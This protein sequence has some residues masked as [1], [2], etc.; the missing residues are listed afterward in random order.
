MEGGPILNQHSEE[1]TAGSNI[2]PLEGAGENSANHEGENTEEKQGREMEAGGKTDYVMDDQHVNPAKVFV[3]GLGQ[4]T[5]T[6]SLRNYFGQYGS[7]V[8]AAVVTDKVSGRSRGFGFC[9]FVHS[10]SADACLNARHKID[11]VSC[12]V[13]RAVPR[14]EARDAAPYDTI[15]Q[16]G[17]LFVGGLPDDITEE[18][19]KDHFEH[20]GRVT[21][22]T[23]M[24]D[25]N[26]HKPRGFGF[27]FFENQR[28]C[29]RATGEHLSLGRA[30]EA[31]KAEP[32]SESRRGGRGG[33][34]GRDRYGGG[35]Y[36]RWDDRRGGRDFYGGYG[37][38]YGDPRGFGGSGRGGGRNDGGSYGGRYDGQGYQPYGFD[39]YQGYYPNDMY[40]GP[41][42]GYGMYGYDQQGAGQGSQMYGYD[43]YGPSGGY[44]QSGQGGYGESGMTSGTGMSYSGGQGR[45]FAP[46]RASSRYG[47]SS[48]VRAAPY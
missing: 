37:G 31:K 18:K 30:C 3:G 26:N 14:D 20:F 15:E 27:I 13:R 7:V 4:G 34:G 24:Y 10:S 5:T 33:G 2:G 9:N 23:L 25:K 8:D 32:R 28:D 6:F 35:D 47:Q 12:E 36:N 48:M 16:P 41:Q 42:Y 39:P 43:G 46:Q 19:L 29:E 17:K 44:S 1:V 40:A 21:Q 45:G 22:A 38:R 11:G